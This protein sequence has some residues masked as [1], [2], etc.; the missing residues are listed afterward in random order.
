MRKPVI[1]KVLFLLL[2]GSV[3]LMARGGADYLTV[4]IDECE[5]IR[6][7]L[8]RKLPPAGR[9]I[10]VDRWMAMSVLHQEKKSE[11]EKIKKRYKRRMRFLPSEINTIDEVSAYI[12]AVLNTLVKNSDKFFDGNFCHYQGNLPWRWSFGDE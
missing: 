5:F 9:G 2:A 4:L 6:L 12:R 3:A 7:M 1:A 11:L 10:T 8:N